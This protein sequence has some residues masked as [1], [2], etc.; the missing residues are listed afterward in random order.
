VVADDV[1]G[2]NPF[3]L[4]MMASA[5][6]RAAHYRREASKLKRMA[7]AETNE[8]VCRRL[9]VFAQE[10]EELAASLDPAT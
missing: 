8:S 7:Q 2:V 5:P 10:Y 9:E 4:M 6:L 1:S 3:K